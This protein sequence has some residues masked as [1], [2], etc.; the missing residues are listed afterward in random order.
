MK[1]P[2]SAASACER[3]G[4]LKQFSDLTLQRNTILVTKIGKPKR[5]QVALRGP[6]RKQHRRS[7]SYRAGPQVHGQVDLDS[8]VKAVGQFEQ[9]SG[10]RNPK[11]LGPELPPIFELNRCR[12]SSHQVDP[13]GADFS[14]W[15]GESGHCDF[16]YLTHPTAAHITKAGSAS[17]NP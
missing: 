5:L 14:P 15:L 8:F 11:R 6:R 13:R 16:H 17:P 12:N 2:Q 9:P 10:N 7:A 3:F 1:W 4:L